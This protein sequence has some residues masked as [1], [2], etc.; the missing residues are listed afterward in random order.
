MLSRAEASAGTGCLTCPTCHSLNTRSRTHG[1]RRLQAS[2]SRVY[3]RCCSVEY[4]SSLFI[5]IFL[6]GPNRDALLR[7]RR[8][9]RSSSLLVWLKSRMKRSIQPIA[10]RFA[11]WWYSAWRWVQACLLPGPRQW[12][13]KLHG[14]A[15][16]KSSPRYYIYSHQATC[17]ST[18]RSTSTEM[19]GVLHNGGNGSQREGLT[20]T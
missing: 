18:G 20:P 14:R 19:Q 4:W 17:S 2:A 8:A 6:V 15:P 7:P 10:F 3:S 12:R 9:K 5:I 1:W 13:S 11:D 16:K